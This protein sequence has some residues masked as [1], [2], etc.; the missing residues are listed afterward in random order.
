MFFL[1]SKP[2]SE[3]ILPPPPPSVQNGAL[4]DIPNENPFVFDEHKK[5]NLENEIPDKSEFNGL[6]ED[7]R[8]ELQPEK[9][10]SKLKKNQFSKKT[11][12]KKRELKKTNVSKK[13]E[14]K[15]KPKT[16]IADAKFPDN[17][18]EFEIQNFDVGKKMNE[19]AI[20]EAPEILE[21]KEEIKSAIDN[22]K[23]TENHFFFNR[24]FE[25]KPRESQLL[26]ELQLTNEM[27]LVQDNIKKAKIALAKLDLKTAKENYIEIMKVYNKLKPSEQAKVYH[28]IMDI[29]SDRKNAEELKV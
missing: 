22:I 21:A 5:Q 18:E 25:K 14:T 17:L 9:E 19:L 10:S 13:T 20:T 27:S 1:K 12:L 26:P 7:F 15:S 16:D 29:Y 6:F 2:K 8:E 3:G 24:F 28:E 4:D 23:N 11:K